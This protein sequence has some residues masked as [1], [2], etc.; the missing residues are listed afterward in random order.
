MKR[1]SQKIIICLMLCLLLAGC[2]PVTETAA[3][4]GV[5]VAINPARYDAGIIIEDDN[6]NRIKV[7]QITKI[8]N[9]FRTSCVGDNVYVEYLW[10]DFEDINIATK[11]ERK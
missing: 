6:G 7:S 1:K 2:G 10:D 5:I 9:D 11:F 4:D 3:I 8:N